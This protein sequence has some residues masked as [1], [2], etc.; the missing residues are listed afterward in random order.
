[1]GWQI[2]IPEFLSILIGKKLIKSAEIS[3]ISHSPCKET[4]LEVKKYLCFVIL[5]PRYEV[6]LLLV[7]IKAIESHRHML[8]T[9]TLNV[10]FL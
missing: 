8:S 1:M 6:S 7:K 3:F 9:L 10:A 2:R 5:C 4:F